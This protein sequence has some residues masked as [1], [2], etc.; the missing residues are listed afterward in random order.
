MLARVEGDPPRLRVL[1]GA[2]TPEE[3][4]ALVGALLTRRV[5][6]VAGVEPE[7]VSRWARSTRPTVP[8]RAGRGAW[9][10]SALPR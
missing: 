3:I 1:R 7:P 8:L 4:A 10:A 5:P 6:A 9:R 2:P